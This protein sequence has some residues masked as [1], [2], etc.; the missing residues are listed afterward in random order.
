MKNNNKEKKDVIAGLNI[1]KESVYYSALFGLAFFVSIALLV[2]AKTQNN[3]GLIIYSA[4]L[5]P[6]FFISAVIAT[7]FACISKN[8]IHVNN[9][10]LVIK[11]FFLTRRLKVSDIKKMTCAQLGD[12]GMTSLKFTMRNK[13]IRYK[14]KNF[15]KEESLHLRHSI[16]K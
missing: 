13:V 16:S 10:K 5:I 1:N 3:K 9:G 7:R 8:K 15:T 14:F 4:V 11:T 2:I 12:K 6:L